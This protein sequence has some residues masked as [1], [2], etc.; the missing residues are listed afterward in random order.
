MSTNI[1]I[2]IAESSAIIRC[3][4]ETL[5]KRLPGFRIQ[6]SEITAADCLTEGLRIY[7]PDILIMNPSIPG[8]CNLQHLKDE[9]GCP[10]MK[11]F[12]LL[13]NVSDPFLLRPYDEQI[14]VYDSAD[15]LK[16]KLERLNTEEVPPE[17]GESDDQQT[18]SSREKRDCRLRGER[19]DKPGDCRP[20]V[21]LHPYR[22]HT[23]T[24]YRTKIAGTQCQWSDR[25]RHC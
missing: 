22:H 18:L 23:P 11:C 25:I 1:K 9:C 19:H 2:A 20:V 14:S 10:D 6:I 17:E 16:H 8:N 12:A 24:E 13:Y 3:G 4:L 5:L 21:S 7:K 15:E